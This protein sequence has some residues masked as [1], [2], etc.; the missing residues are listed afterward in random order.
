MSK[1]V[2]QITPSELQ[3]LIV[4]EVV[5]H[6]NESIEIDNISYEGKTL[7]IRK[8]DM[9]EPHDNEYIKSKGEIIWDILQQGYENKGG[10]KGFRSCKDMLNKSPF[11]VLGFCNDEIITV[12]VYNTYLGGNKCVGATC[13]KDENHN[14]AVKLLE[15]IMEYHIHNWDKWV[16]LEASGKIEEMCRAKN[17]FNVPSK[18]AVIYLTN[19]EYT[20]TDDYHYERKIGGTIETKTIFGFK[21]KDTFNLLSDEINAQ[22]RDFINRQSQKKVNEN[23]E[24]DRIW[25]RYSKNL[26]KMD[27]TIDII[28]YFVYLK[29]DELINEFP[30]ESINILKT[31]ITQAEQML[32]NNQ[33]S[34]EEIFLYKNCIDD[35]YRVLATSTILQTI[36]FAS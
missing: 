31:A 29:D 15:M 24:R 6:L 16:W 34:S 18:Y 25:N 19:K 12:S 20:I 23:D 26:T 1:K 5:E 33:Y 27:K 3:Q 32:N 8:F 30:V 11:Y 10:F 14:N 17:G 7:S 22:V 13:V 2:V 4:K 9:F 28:N 35:G 36:K 21:S